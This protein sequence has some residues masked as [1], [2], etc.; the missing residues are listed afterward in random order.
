[1]PIIR[2]FHLVL[3]RPSLITIYKA[4]IRPNLDYRA[5]IFDQAF[6]NSFHQI[7]ESIH[8]SAAMKIIGAIRGTP[9]EK[10]YQ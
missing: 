10:L 2:K 1:M 4:F 8:Y 3:P 5:V 6:N 9:K 7:L